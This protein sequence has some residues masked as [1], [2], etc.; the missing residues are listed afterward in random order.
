MCGIV[1]ILDGTGLI[2]D[3]KSVFTQM[4]LVGQLRGQHGTG[5]IAIPKN[6]KSHVKVVKRALDSGMFLD[7]YAANKVLNQYHQYTA[8]IGHN[9]LAT[10]GGITHK[11]SHPFRSGPFTL[12]HNGTLRTRY[13]LP[14]HEKYKVDSENIV[15]SFNKIGV[16]ETLKLLNGSFALVWHDA[17]DNMVHMVRNYE[18]PLYFAT[19]LHDRQV[20]FAS[21]KLML[22]W[23]LDRNKV[24]Y[25]KMYKLETNHIITFD[26]N[27]R[28]VGEFT[29]KKV[30]FRPSYIEQYNKRSKGHKKNKGHM[31][32]INS[33]ENYGVRMNERIVFKSL[34][35]VPFT[36]T[37][38]RGRLF[39]HM[40]R[41]NFLSVEFI[42]T[43]VD[44]YENGKQYVGYV[45][46]IKYIDGDPTIMVT[47]VQNYTEGEKRF[48]YANNLKV[49]GPNGKMIT[50]KKWDKLTKDG[51]C[52][53]S[54]NL[55]MKDA[56]DITWYADDAPMCLDCHAGFI[57][58][59]NE[60][61]N[62]SQ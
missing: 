42:G 19:A 11:T 23:I 44:G 3:D 55:E 2:K 57:I 29:S 47:N 22:E 20:F 9:R 30:E 52:Y 54:G 1:G 56:K 8:L 16:E 4:L 17:K 43:K 49:V 46:G 15:H 6:I 51:C 26:L 35:F 62:Q 37:I 18:R 28:K 45:T 40:T 48:D 12:V 10:T 61:E 25:D 13:D 36:D 31:K 59:Q 33:L 58:Q 60:N 5:I 41:G 50:E 53:C 39:G 34:N 14:D 24:K 21:E 27:S 7:L 32:I 38:A